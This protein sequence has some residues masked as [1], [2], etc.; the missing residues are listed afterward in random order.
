MV[1]KSDDLIFI[2]IGALTFFRQNTELKCH[3]KSSEM[4]TTKNT[5]AKIITLLISTFVIDVIKFASRIGEINPK[6]LKIT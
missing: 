4:V 5:K 1:S 3:K 6:A 2:I